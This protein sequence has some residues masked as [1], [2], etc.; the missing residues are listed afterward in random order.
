MHHDFFNIISREEFESL[1]LSF[2]PTGIEKSSIADAYG[3]VLGEDI[4]SPE[5]LPPANR[6][7]MDGYAVNARNAFGA[8]EGNPAYL[9]CCAELRVDEAPDFTLKPG[10][11]A[12]IPTGGTLPDGADAVVMVEHTHELGSGTIEIR[13]SS[14]PGENIMLKGEDTAKGENI[15]EAGHTVRF[16]DVGLL[17]A[18]GIGNVSVHK[19]PRIGIISTGDELV[20]IESPSRAGSIRD[21]NSHTLR[22]L[23]SKAGGIPVNYGIV[24]DEIEKLEATLAKAI[25]ENDIVL[26]SGGSSVGMR[27]LTVRAIESMPESKILAHGVAISPG[28]PTILGK[29]GSK[30]VLGLPGQVTSVQVV[31]LSIV[32]PFIRHIMGQ[33]DAFACLDRPIRLAELGRNTPSKQGREDYVRVSLK[34]R[35]GKLP[36]AHPVYGKSGLLKTLIKADGLMIIPADTEGLYAGDQI[37]VWLI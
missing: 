33:K 24:R 5:D 20:E 21:V 25:A 35:E 11:C 34:H 13:K 12:A 16:Q 2:A 36:I 37:Q 4:L 18:L 10:D 3:L 19:K 27:D 1:L 6:S 14:A 26:L 9:E 7:C 29:V 30:P 28:K 32:M 8:T 22:C 23:V 17:A 15:Y 31:M